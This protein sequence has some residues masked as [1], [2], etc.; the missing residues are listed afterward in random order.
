[1]H[2]F[3]FGTNTAELRTLVSQLR[4]SR[5][6]LVSEA[7]TLLGAGNFLTA[8][9]V[10]FLLCDARRSWATHGLQLLHKVRTGQF[11]HAAPDMPFLLISDDAGVVHA[12]DKLDV[13]AHVGSP[14]RLS[15]LEGAVLR[16]T[17]APLFIDFNRVL[18]Y[19]QR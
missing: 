5:A 3:L 19:S 13:S 10:D 9:K 15:D 14:L 7:C 8:K 4:A 2:Y 12:A 1:M 11:P 18:G 6:T 17:R 16:A